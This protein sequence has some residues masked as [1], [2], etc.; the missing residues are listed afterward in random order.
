MC[1]SRRAPDQGGDRSCPWLQDKSALLVLDNCEHLI[2]ACAELSARLLA[3]VSGLRI[4]ATSRE[5]LAVAGEAT[6]Q[7]PA[8]ALPAES[9]RD[10]LE[11]E[12][13][14][15]FVD[16]ASYAK[17]ELEITD[18]NAPFVGELCRRLEGI[19]LAIELAA[20]RVRALTVEQILRRLDDRFRLLAGGSRGA[21]TRQ[22]TLRAALDWSYDLLTEPERVLLQRLSVFSGGWTLEAAETVAGPIVPPSSASADPLPEDVFD[23]LSR[24][25]DKSLVATKETGSEDRFRMLEIVREYASDRLRESGAA[26]EIGRRHSDYFGSLANVVSTSF[27]GPKEASWLSQLEAEHDNLRA[28]LSWLLANDPE[29]CLV[30]AAALSDFWSLHGHFTEGSRWM[31]AALAKCEQAPSVPRLRAIR[32]AGEFAWRQGD[33]PL[34]QT[35]LEESLRIARDVGDRRQIAWSTFHLALV[36][37]HRSELEASEAY[38]HECLEIGKEIGDDRLVGN[39]LNSLGE[40]AR[41]AGD[42]LKAVPFYEQSLATHRRMGHP[43]GISLTLCNLGAALCDAGDVDGASERYR[44]ALPFLR[45]LGNSMGTS[46]ALDGLGAVA[47]RCEQWERAARLAGSAAA[48]RDAIGGELE[49]ADRSLRDRYLSKLRAHLA[50]EAL[51]AAMADGRATSRDRAIEQALAS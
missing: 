42:W 27:V 24:L 37:Q 33:L 5:S 47:A 38:L 22:Q 43:V 48:L 49:P 44:E 6:W 31:M 51:E 34:A 19:P 14:Q 2:G 12:A 11:C 16:R 4:L 35:R 32:A 20:A 45:D 7:V 30:V 29:R 3:R 26:L 18:A 10:F 23:L 13:V 8:L 25:V 28:A 41:I 50:P 46:L 39:T 21:P 40:S 15:L 17:P 9:A 1:A 36:I